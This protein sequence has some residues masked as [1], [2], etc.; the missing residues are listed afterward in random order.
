VKKPGFGEL[1]IRPYIIFNS[2]AINK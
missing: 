1:H 2:M